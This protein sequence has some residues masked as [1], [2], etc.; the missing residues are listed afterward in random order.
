M[1]DGVQPDPVLPERSGDDVVLAR[2]GGL[3]M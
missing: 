1:T 3:L 2:D